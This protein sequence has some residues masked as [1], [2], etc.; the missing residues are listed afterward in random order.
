ML[1]KHKLLWNNW[2]MCWP[3]SFWSLVC[4]QRM[5]GMWRMTPQQCT[6][7]SPSRASTLSNG[8]VQKA[9]LQNGAL[10][11]GATPNNHRLLFQSFQN[12]PA[13]SQVTSKRATS[14]SRQQQHECDGVHLSSIC[15]H[16][17][18]VRAQTRRNLGCNQMQQ[19]LIPLDWMLLHTFH[20]CC[21]EPLQCPTFNVS[22][23]TV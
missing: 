6:E 22:I 4:V 17:L 16:T 14:S 23:E 15:P 8:T 9:E 13:W 18:L 11:P 2:G 21:N 3:S 7:T 1:S 20:W 12:K 10:K 5:A 19:Q